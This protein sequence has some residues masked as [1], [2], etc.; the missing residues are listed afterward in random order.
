MKSG[1]CRRS[2]KCVQ[3]AEPLGGIRADLREKSLTGDLKVTSVVWKEMGV[4]FFKTL[5][6]SWSGI[7]SLFPCAL[8]ARG[9]GEGRGLPPGTISIARGV[10]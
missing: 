2:G 5:R 4:C 1:F 3:E 8:G 10:H 7:E 9:L 6:V